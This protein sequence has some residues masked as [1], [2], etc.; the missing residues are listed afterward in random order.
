M[1][2]STNII[3]ARAYYSDCKMAKQGRGIK[4]SKEDTPTCKKI[5]NLLYLSKPFRL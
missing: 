1:D 2:W 3:F 5:I 4:Y